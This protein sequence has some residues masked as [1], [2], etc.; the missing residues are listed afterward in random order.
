[1]LCCDPLQIEAPFDSGDAPKAFLSQNVTDQESMYCGECGRVAYH[2]PESGNA[3][4][5]CRA[6]A[7]YQAD[8][9]CADCMPLSYDEYS[10]ER[11]STLTGEPS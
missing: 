7:T 9:Y 2:W 11:V 3:P 1:M 5:W 10:G 4:S 8:T 6:G